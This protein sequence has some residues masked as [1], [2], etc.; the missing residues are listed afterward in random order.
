LNPW[1]EPNECPAH[2]KGDAGSPRAHSAG[3]V[4]A[5]LPG[6]DDGHMGLSEPVEAAVSAAVEAAES[7]VKRLLNG[8]WPAAQFEFEIVAPK[9]G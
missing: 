9:Q 4:R 5:R 8:D 3:W 2:G 7:L 6:G 1:H